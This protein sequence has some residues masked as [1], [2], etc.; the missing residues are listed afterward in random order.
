MAVDLDAYPLC[1]SGVT[2]A[3]WDPTTFEFLSSWQKQCIGSWLKAEGPNR[4][5]PIMPD[6][7][8]TWERGCPTDF[9]NACL[10]SSL[11]L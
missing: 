8:A 9:W 1:S 7:E 11:F 6:D 3:V 10:A 4:P 2:L 5:E